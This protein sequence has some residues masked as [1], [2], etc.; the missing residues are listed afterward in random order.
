MAGSFW[1]SW[2]DLPRFAGLNNDLA[3]Y[4]S[5]HLDLGRG[6]RDVFHIGKTLGLGGVFLGEMKA[7][8]AAHESF[9]R[10][11]TSLRLKSCRTIVSCRKVRSEPSRND[12]RRL[13]SRRK[14]S[15]DCVRLPIDAG[16][17]MFGAMLEAIPIEMAADREYEI[18]F[19]LRKSPDRFHCRC[20]RTADRDREPESA[21]R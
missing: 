21:R 9:R 19:G 5:V 20:V 16:T 14:M 17:L 1:I 3:G 6:D 13:G 8:A 7:L 10:M 4:V 12:A 15:F 2:A 18:G 11:R